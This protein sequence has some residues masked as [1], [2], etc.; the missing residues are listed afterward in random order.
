MIVIPLQG[1]CTLKHRKDDI[2]KRGPR[3]KSWHC[4]TCNALLFADKKPACVR[5][6]FE[7]AKAQAKLEAE[8]LNL[9]D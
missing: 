4:E 1:R 2:P 8:R 9:K 7:N 3:E 5:A 6:K